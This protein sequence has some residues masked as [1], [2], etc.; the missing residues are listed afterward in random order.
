MG[1][2]LDSQ[3]TMTA[4][5][6]IVQLQTSIFRQPQFTLNKVVFRCKRSLKQ[7]KNR[8][9]VS[10]AQRNV[11]SISPSNISLMKCEMSMNQK[12][13]IAFII[14]ALSPCSFIRHLVVAT[15]AYCTSHLLDLFRSLVMNN[16]RSEIKQ[17]RR[18]N[19]RRN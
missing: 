19:G 4:E 14:V 5:S 2:R 1:S 15:T 13:L 3:F 18:R 7:S 16:V 12:L 10:K 6:E 11:I 17:N 8:H 9:T